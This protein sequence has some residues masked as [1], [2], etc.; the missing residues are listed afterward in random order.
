MSEDQKWSETDPSPRMKYL[1]EIG[2]FSTMRE[3]EDWMNSE[4][5][6]ALLAELDGPDPEEEAL[7]SLSSLDRKSVV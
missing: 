1:M 7:E 3:M 4:K 5:D 6:P 2:G